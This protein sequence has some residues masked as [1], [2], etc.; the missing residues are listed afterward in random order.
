MEYEKLTYFG[1]PIHDFF[2]FEHKNDMIP[3]NFFVETFSI[4]YYE[5]FQ[6]VGKIWEDKW[7][8][9]HFTYFVGDP[10]I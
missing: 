4:Y 7:K 1:Y 5:Q 3:L 9:E 6:M 2:D 10:L 8:H